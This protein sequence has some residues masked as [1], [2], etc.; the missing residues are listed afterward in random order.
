MRIAPSPNFEREIART[1]I[2][3]AELA[4]RAAIAESTLHAIINPS[5]QPIRKG[6]VRSSTAWRLAR[7]VAEAAGM[8]VDEAYA[9]LFIEVERARKIKE[10]PDLARAS[11]HL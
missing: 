10:A 8:T 6:S 2:N 9:K 7:V 1:G 3:K 5:I 4:R 11:T